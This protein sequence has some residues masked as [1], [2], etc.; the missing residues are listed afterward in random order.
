VETNIERLR[1]VEFPKFRDAET[2][3]A[4]GLA[5][6]VKT[7]KPDIEIPQNVEAR[8]NAA[9]LGKCKDNIPLSWIL[10]FIEVF[11]SINV[12]LNVES[13]AYAIQLAKFIPDE[14]KNK[15][16]IKLTRINAKE[17]KNGSLGACAVLVD[18]GI[19]QGGGAIAH[20][21]V[22]F[23]SEKDKK[24]NF[25]T[26]SDPWSDKENVKIHESTFDKALFGLNYLVGWGN[27]A[28]SLH[29]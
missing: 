19:L 12:V 6:L 15:I 8:I 16:D 2:C 22:I 24:T 14:A 26:Y 11:P 7:Q 4:A 27:L 1:N 20:T 9:K 25:I 23:P 13:E 18:K 5:Y 17:F 3:I 10:G 21:I 28:F 29:Q